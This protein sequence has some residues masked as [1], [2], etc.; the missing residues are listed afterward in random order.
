[1]S[2]SNRRQTKDPVGGAHVA[3]S[4]EIDGRMSHDGVKWHLCDVSNS[5]GNA[6]GATH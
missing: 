3:C 1:M 4:E 6:F 2:L 5:A